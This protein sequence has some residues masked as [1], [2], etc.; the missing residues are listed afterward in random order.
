MLQKITRTS[1]D[2]TIAII[3][4]MVGAVF[5]SEGIQKF[6][7]PAL[8]GA[9]RFESIGLPI[10]EL[11]GYF[12]GSFEIVCG[13]LILLGLLTRLSSIPLI[14]IMSI[15]IITTK[16][17]IAQQ[18]GFWQMAHAARTDYAMLLGSLFLLIKG[19][20]NWSLDRYFFPTA[21]S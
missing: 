6:L 19:S 4:L 9:G 8:R 1:R 16:I 20:G 13:G 5:L 7:Y 17:P 14:T 12:V 10:P 21:E 3:R 2:N 11:L 18:K 15:A